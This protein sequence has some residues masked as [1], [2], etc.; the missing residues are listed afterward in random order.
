MMHILVDEIPKHPE[1]CLFSISSMDQRFY[2]CKLKMNDDYDWEYRTF[3]GHCKCSLSENK[4]CPYL[5]RLLNHFGNNSKENKSEEEFAKIVEETRQKLYNKLGVPENLIEEGS[6]AT[7]T[8]ISQ[9]EEEK[10]K[11]HFR[12]SID[13]AINSCYQEPRDWDDF[14]GNNKPIDDSK[15][16]I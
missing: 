15:Y 9:Y 5:K 4:D 3:N 6:L 8:R 16:F 2:N 1:E 11:K 14:V 13:A 7:A 12:E 10:F